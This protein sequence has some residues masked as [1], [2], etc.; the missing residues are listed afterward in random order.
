[1]AKAGK[2]TFRLNKKEFA[3]I[4]ELVRPQVE[5]AGR[6]V[7]ERTRSKV[8]DDVPV[9]VRNGTS[10]TGRPHSIVGIFHPSGLPRQAKHGVLTSAAAEAGLEVT[11][12][13]GRRR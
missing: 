6:A 9:R 1:M 10:N 8:P 2:P 13:K 12:Y 3:K 11:R 4:A 5:S 7:G